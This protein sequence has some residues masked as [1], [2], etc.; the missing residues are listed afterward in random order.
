[1]KLEIWSDVVCPWC[2]IGKRRVEEALK[3]FSGSEN[4]EI[5]YRSFE[6]DP[7]AP[8][9]ATQSMPEMLA[10]KYG[11]GLQ[12]AQMMMARVSQVAAGDGLEFNLDQSKPER[13]FDAHRLLHL[14]KMKGQDAQLRLKERLMRAYFTEGRAIGNPEELVRLAV[15]TGLPE[16]EVRAVVEDLEKF[17]SEVRADE[18]KAQ[19]HGIRGVPFVV[20]DG[21]YG[22][23]GAQPAEV[24]R[25]AFEQAAKT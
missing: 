3:D 2:Y 10:S 18:R 22:I 14:A 11:G 16:D 12:N 13:T 8:V 5:V 21:K 19:E 7:N 25:A 15:E 17:A 23:S 4:V 1:M 6:L 24:F 20:V 9:K